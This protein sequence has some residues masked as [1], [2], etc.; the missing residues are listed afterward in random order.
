MNSRLVIDSF[1]L[2]I[3][4]Q[5]I[6]ETENYISV[7]AIIAAPGIQEYTSP[8]GSVVRVLVPE[9]TL[10]DPS[11]LASVAQAPVTDEHPE[12]AVTPENVRKYQIGNVGDVVEY[13]TKHGV[14]VRL[15][16]RDR[17]AI[18]HV[19]SRSKTDTSPAYYADYDDTPGVD[20][21][22]GPYDR[23]QVK[24]RATNHIAHCWA[25]RGKDARLLLDSEDNPQPT[26]LATAWSSLFPIK[27]S[28]MTSEQTNT[29]QQHIDGIK[30]VLSFVDSLKMTKDADPAKIDPELLSSAKTSLVDLTAL[31]GT[32]ASERDQINAQLEE[33]RGEFAAVLA[34]IQGAP[35]GEPTGE[36]PPAGDAE[37]AAPGEAPLDP[38]AE[39]MAQDSK[40]QAYFN[41]RQRALKMAAEY[42]ID[43]VDTK[44]NAE[45]QRAV[46]EKHTAGLPE[47]RKLQLDSA[48]EVRSAFRTIEALRS[49]KSDDAAQPW[50]FETDAAAPKVNQGDVLRKQYSE[51]R[52]A[53]QK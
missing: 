52:A 20:P 48:I 6:I 29:Y 50:K 1:T 45:L 8:D 32:M 19:R 33:L 23:I 40:F 46:V 43:S 7:P 53:S 36:A 44:S 28:D 13:D 35:A 34:Q 21:D 27:D 42:A 3:S 17:A 24:R 18:E 37:G 4:D 31:I 39:A 9:S 26:D 5:D 12:E 11:W 16:L 14:V 10:V 30:S 41:E 38:E 15:I 22:H 25:G 51:A 47:D 2:A 49:M